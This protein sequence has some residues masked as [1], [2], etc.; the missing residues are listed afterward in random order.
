MRLRASPVRFVQRVCRAQVRRVEDVGAR[1]AGRTRRRDA[2]F[3]GTSTARIGLARAGACT[4]ACRKLG[5]RVLAGMSRKGM[6]GAVLDKPVNERLYGSLS[7]AVMAAMLGA[8]IIRVHDVAETAD[9][10]G[11][12]R[13]VGEV[14]L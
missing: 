1:G 4:A 7:V 2:G 8:D 6:I 10:L 12:V 14:A 13:A 5:V 9:A 3:A 11:M